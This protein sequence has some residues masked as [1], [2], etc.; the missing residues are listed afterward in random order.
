[1]LRRKL[2]AEAIG[3][4]FLLAT[5]VGSGVMG[6]QLAQGNDAIALLANAGA[7]AAML[8]LLIVT[9]GP[10]SGAHFNP[11]VTMAL[12]LRGEIGTREA[13]LYVIVQVVAA[14]AGVILAHAMF[15]LE[16]IQPGVHARSGA[17]QWIGELVATFG[18]LLTIL[19]GARHRANAVAGLVAC[20]IFA[21]Y[22]FTSSTSFANPAVTLARSLTQTFA[23]IRTQDVGAFV[24][25]QSMGMLL[26]LAAVSMLAGRG[27]SEAPHATR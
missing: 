1:M 10:I 13:L 27:D 23:G 14:I 7:T 21:A 3:T 17:G 26:A 4:L 22:W 16:L 19:L 25:A 8:Y 9:L 6:T 24:L 15:G 5:V 11:A 18:L 2:L 12:R 20:Y